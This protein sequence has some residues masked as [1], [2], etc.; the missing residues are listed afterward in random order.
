[1]HR[2]NVEPDDGRI[3]GRRLPEIEKSGSI[4]TN[5]H[6]PTRSQSLFT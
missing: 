6:K 2:L 1:L 3:A 4:L 5:D